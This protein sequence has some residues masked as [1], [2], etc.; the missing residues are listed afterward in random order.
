MGLSLCLLAPLSRLSQEGWLFP[1]LGLWLLSLPTHQSNSPLSA[2][3]WQTHSFQHTLVP[4]HLGH[5]GLPPGREASHPQGPLTALSSNTV[6][7]SPPQLPA[8]PTSE[9]L[10]LPLSF[11]FTSQ[12]FL[13]FM[14]FLSI[15]SSLSPLTQPLLRAPSLAS[16]HLCLPPPTH[17]SYSHQNDVRKTQP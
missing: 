7:R 4:T 1:R 6:R 13:E 8:S 11:H 14:P 9:S 15:S 12:V 16:K 10:S 5:H 2:L 3:P 17:P